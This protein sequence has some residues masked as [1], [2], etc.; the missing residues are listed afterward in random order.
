M[1][2]EREKYI[3]TVQLDVPIF[4]VEELKLYCYGLGETK[5]TISEIL[6]DG[7]VLEKADESLQGFPTNNITSVRAARAK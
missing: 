2:V 1:R 3:I 4:G 6:R 5:T 7:L